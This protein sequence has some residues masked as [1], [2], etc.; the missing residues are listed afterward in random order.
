MGG[1]KEQQGKKWG[2]RGAAGRPLLVFYLLQEGCFLSLV[3]YSQAEA[4]SHPANPRARPREPPSSTHCQILALIT[5]PARGHLQLSSFHFPQ[6][7]VLQ[8]LG[9][10]LCPAR[11]FTEHQHREDTGS[12]APGGVLHP[13]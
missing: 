8:S 6:P 2:S 9:L 7:R 4:V 10:S 12:G 3:F 5:C 1:L 13:W 11:A